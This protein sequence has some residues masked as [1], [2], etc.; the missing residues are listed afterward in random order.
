[1]HD[2]QYYID[3]IQ[4]LHRRRSGWWQTGCLVRCHIGVHTALHDH[5]EVFKHNA[6]RLRMPVSKVSRSYLWHW[7]LVRRHLLVHAE[8]SASSSACRTVDAHAAWH[9]TPLPCSNIHHCVAHC[10]AMASLGCQ[11]GMHECA[12]PIGAW[13]AGRGRPR[14]VPGL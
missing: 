6:Q 3:V 5:G 7:S 8:R 9:S 14:Y 4:V 10:A 11:A 1:M 13:P 12:C 2:S